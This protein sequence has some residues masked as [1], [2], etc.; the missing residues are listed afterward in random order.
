MPRRL[1]L[2]D[3]GA[4]PDSARRSNVELRFTTPAAVAS[5]AETYRSANV[6]TATSSRNARPVSGST[7]SWISVRRSTACLKDLCAVRSHH[8]GVEAMTAAAN[9]A[10]IKTFQYVNG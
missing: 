7:P 9:S 10:G 1:L 4:D 6:A 5:T 8:R 2:T 3:T